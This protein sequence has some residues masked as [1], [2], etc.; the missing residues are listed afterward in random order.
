MPCP[1]GVADAG[2]VLLPDLYLLMGVLLRPPNDRDAT[3]AET[4]ALS[5]GRPT[6]AFQN[7]YRCKD[8]S[9]RWLARP[10]TQ[11]R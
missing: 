2:L 7:R 8:A 9:Y 5:T 11:P 4:R 10:V 1:P 3:V 6:V